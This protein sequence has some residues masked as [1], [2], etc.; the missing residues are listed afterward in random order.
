MDR[1]QKELEDLAT[2]VRNSYAA[3][4]KSPANG[5]LQGFNEAVSA[6]WDYRSNA[7]FPVGSLRIVTPYDRTVDFFVS[8]AKNNIE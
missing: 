7:D 5:A 6:Y 1:W 4:E 3:Y 8:L 2:K